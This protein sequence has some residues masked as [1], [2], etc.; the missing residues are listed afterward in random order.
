MRGTRGFFLEAAASP[1]AWFGH[2]PVYVVCGELMVWWCRVCCGGGADCAVVV[3][4]IV[5]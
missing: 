2:L 3:V 5:L 1:M 4:P